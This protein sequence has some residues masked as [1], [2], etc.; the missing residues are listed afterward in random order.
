MKI[1]DFYKAKNKQ[2]IK[3]N[4][5]EEV[6]EEKRFL[7]YV[8]GY[9]IKAGQQDAGVTSAF[10]SIPASAD[11]FGEN[12]NAVNFARLEKAF[13]EICKKQHPQTHSIMLLN[14][15]PLGRTTETNN[16]QVYKQELE[17]TDDD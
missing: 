16:I 13:L 3:T 4:D 1:I 15:I 11:I 6:E 9:R 8:Y 2:S 12:L 7:Y 10:I 17:R 5:K 14:I